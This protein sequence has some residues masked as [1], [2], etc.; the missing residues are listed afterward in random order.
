MKRVLEVI[1]GFGYGG[2]RAF[3]MNYLKYLDKEK[4]QVDIYVFGYGESPF[5]DQVRE[6][7]ANIYFEPENNVRHIRRFVRQLETFMKEHGPY[8][9]VHANNNLISAWVLLAARK[10]GVPIRLSHSHSSCH[11]DGSLAQKVYGYLR[12]FIID[13]VA[14]EKLACGQLA[15]ETMYG[16]NADFKIIANGISVDRFMH[17]NE[18]RVAELRKQF[19]IPEKAKIYAN[20][21]RMDPQKNHLFAIEVFRE[22]HK[23]EP[24]SI[25]LYGGVTPVISPTVDE[26]QAKI[27]DY[28]LETSCRYTGPIMDVE[29]LYHLTDLWIYCSAYEGLPFGPIELQAASVP[30]IASDVITKEIDLGLGLVYFLSLNDPPK[31]W[32]EL[33]VSIKKEMLPEDNIRLAFKKYNFDIKQNVKI[34]EAIYN[35]KNSA[36]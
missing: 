9:V 27:K 22:I 20:V 31:K 4:F 8:D 30:V 11:F 7:G 36:L 10:V 24:N 34:L 6:I 33:A 21:T 25:F 15:G 14:T 12:R 26:M 13:C 17:R 32:A 23:L 1:Y 3:I 19:N 29:Q 18:E 16:K 35:G 2:I 5:T 28:G